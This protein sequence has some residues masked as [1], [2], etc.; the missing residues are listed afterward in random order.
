LPKLERLL[1][2][3]RLTREQRAGTI[4]EM[5][6]ICGV[7]QR[8]IFRYLNTL[9]SLDLPDELRAGTRKAA[10]ELLSQLVDRDDQC[11]LCFAL[12][13]NPLVEYEYLAGRLDQIKRSLS[14][15]RLAGGGI[16]RGGVIE[17]EMSARP[18]RKTAGDR[19]LST[20][21]AACQSGDCLSVKVRGNDE[22]SILQP[23]AIKIQSKGIRLSFRAPSRKRYLTYDLSSIASVRVIKKAAGSCS[24]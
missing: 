2:L 15:R 21:V 6:Q 7:S 8:T 4:R 11:L 23:R 13:H 22:V 3:A 14:G 17:I 18:K 24:R 19:I 5:S 1:K 20:F 12:D 9:S 10:T 16:L